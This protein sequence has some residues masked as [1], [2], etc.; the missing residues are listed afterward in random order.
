[1][2]NL[3]SPLREEPRKVGR[4]ATVPDKYLKMRHQQSISRYS[5]PAAPTGSQADS[6]TLSGSLCHHLICAYAR[7]AAMGS[8]ARDE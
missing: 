4:R 8:M 1:M 6:C 2:Q 5:S 3:S 7:G